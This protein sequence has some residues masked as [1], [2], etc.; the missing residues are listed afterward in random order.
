MKKRKKLIKTGFLLLTILG[1]LNIALAV[2]A[3]EVGVPLPAP[4]YVYDGLGQDEDRTR[5]TTRLSANWAE[6]PDPRV[7]GYQYAIGTSP[8]GT[9][10]VNWT[11]LPATKRSVTRSGLSLSH[12]VTYY[13][14]VRA[15]DE[16]MYPG[17]E[18]SSDGIR[19]DI[20]A[21]TLRV[22][23]SP[24]ALTF[25]AD[26]TSKD[27][28]Y[29]LSI[30][31]A[32]GVR[33]N[34]ER[35][36]YEQDG[37]I[38]RT[39]TPVIFEHIPP[40]GRLVLGR[41]I[42]LDNA[43]RNQILA[44]R[45]TATFTLR[46]V[47]SG[48]DDRANP[49][50]GSSTLE[51][52]VRRRPAERFEITGVEILL[53]TG[54]WGLDEE[55]RARIRFQASNGPGYVEGNLYIDDV[56]WRS[57]G[58]SDIE[59]EDEIETPPV[60][61]GT[62]GTHTLRVALVA[63][64]PVEASATYE[65]SV[66][67]SIMDRLSSLNILK[68]EGT[69]W[70]ILQEI[71]GTAT[72]VDVPEGEPEGGA[73]Y[74][75]N[76][77][78]KL[79][80][81]S[82]NNQVVDVRMENLVIEFNSADPPN[83]RIISG[84]LITPP[85]T[86]PGVLFSLYH[87]FLEITKVE[88]QG[89]WN[90][91][92][93]DADLNLPVVNQKLY[94][95]TG[96]TVRYDGIEG[97]SFDE[98]H[99]FNLCGLNF[100]LRQVTI[101]GHTHPP[102]EL[103]Y[104]SEEVYA[105]LSGEISLRRNGRD[106]AI[107]SFSGFRFGVNI[108]SGDVNVE[109]NFSLTD[110]FRFIPGNDYFNLQRLTFE[111]ER[112]GSYTYALRAEGEVR[113]PQPFDRFGEQNFNF[114]FTEE[115]IEGDIVLI[116][117]PTSEEKTQPE[118]MSGP[119]SDP[120][121]VPFWVCQLDLT[122]LGID[123]AF[124]DGNLR[125]E[126][127]RIKVGADLWVNERD[128][129][130]LRQELG[131]KDVP[132]FT[133][134]FDGNL[135]WSLPTEISVLRDKKI[136]LGSVW[137]GIE[138]LSIIPVPFALI[139]S[140]GFGIDVDVVESSVGIDGLRVDIDG[141]VDWGTIREGEFEVLDVVTIGV[142]SI[143]YSDS[144]STSTVK[145]DATD[146]G[147]RRSEE[148]LLSVSKYLRVVNANIDLAN[149]FSGN[150]DELLV[151]EET[152]GETKFALRG[153]DIDIAGFNLM[154]DFE[155]RNPVIS[156]AGAI[157]G[158]GIDLTVVGAVG[159]EERN[160]TFGLFV[161][162]D[163]PPTVII[164]P[165]LLVLTEVG[166]GFFYNPKQD[167]IK[168][169][170]ELCGVD[171]S[172]LA[173]KAGSGNIPS[174]FPEPDPGSFAMLLYGGLYCIEEATVKGQALISLTGGYFSLDAHAE[175]LPDQGPLA[176]G[177]LHF[178]VS[179]SPAFAEGGVWV[180][181]DIINLIEGDGYFEF[182]IFSH[183]GEAVWAIMGGAEL[184]VIRIIDI[185]SEFFMGPPGFM[186][187]GGI[188]AGIDLWIVSGGFSLE[189]MIWYER[190]PPD[191]T[192]GA[193][194]EGEVWGEVLGGLAGARAGLYGALI[195]P[196]PEVITGAYIS[197]EVCWVEV[198]SG[199][200]WISIGTR[201]I[202]GGTGR[203]SR[204]DEILD[205]A[206]NMADYMDR[207]MQEVKDSIVDMLDN[208]G[209]LDPKT[210]ELLG[211]MLVGLESYED[212]A[213]FYAW[214]GLGIPGG[215][216]ERPSVCNDILTNILWDERLYHMGEPK[217]L[218][219]I[220]AERDALFNSYKDKV[221]SINSLQEQIMLKLEER[222]P[223]IE[224]LT[225]TG[226]QEL[227]ISN[228]V[229]GMQYAAI[230]YVTPEGERRSQ[231][232]RVGFDLDEEMADTQKDQMRQNKEDQQ[233][234]IRS[235]I[236]RTEEFRELLGKVD[237][238]LYGRRMTEIALIG[239]PVKLASLKLVP[240]PVLL[241]PE[242]ALMDL[243]N[244]Y[245]EAFDSLMNYYIK[246]FGYLD[247]AY[248]VSLEK[249]RELR[250][251][252]IE[253]TQAL[254]TQ[255]ETL[256]LGWVKQLTRI[257]RSI[258]MDL[259]NKARE[260]V[261]AEGEE[262]PEDFPAPPLEINEEWTEDEWRNT[263][264]NFGKELWYYIPLSGYQKA[265]SSISLLPV[266]R[267]LY[268][269]KMNFVNA[270][271]EVTTHLDFVYDRRVRLYELLYDLYDELS[272][273]YAGYP[274]PVRE[275]RIDTDSLGLIEFKEI[276]LDRPAER[277]NSGA[278][279]GPDTGFVPETAP[280]IILQVERFARP[281][282][283]LSPEVILPTF[284]T[285]YGT[286]KERIST[287]LLPP[288]ITGFSGECRGVDSRAGSYA[289]IDS[290]F[291]AI[292]PVGVVEYGMKIEQPDYLSEYERESGTMTQDWFS[293]GNQVE[294]FKLLFVPGGTSHGEGRWLY[295][296]ARGPAGNYIY[297][298]GRIQVGYMTT[299]R[300][301]IDIADTTP[302]TTPVVDDEG[303][304]TRNT[305]RLYTR[306]ESSDPESGIAEY[307]YRVITYRQIGKIRTLIPEV[308]QDWTS[309]GV[310]EELN[311]RGLTLENNRTYF[312]QVKTKNG[313]G[314]W[315]PV[316]CSDGIR[317]D[318]VPPRITSL[319]FR[320]SEPEGE[321]S[322]TGTGLIPEMGMP[323]VGPLRFYPN[324]LYA[325]FA[326]EDNES[327]IAE[328]SF[329]LLDEN[330]S[331]LRTGTTTLTYLSLQ[332]LPLS[333]GATYTLSVTVRD[334][335]GWMSEPVTSEVTALFDDTTAPPAPSPRYVPARKLGTSLVYLNPGLYL[336]STSIVKIRWDPVYDPESGVYEYQVGIGRTREN[337]DVLPWTGVGR[338]TEYEN[339]SLKLENGQNYYLMVKVI[340]GAGLESV[341]IVGPLLVDTTPPV[342]PQLTFLAPMR[343][344]LCCQDKESLISL[345]RYAIYNERGER[346]YQSP[347]RGVSLPGSEITHEFNIYS[348]ELRH[349]HI[350]EPQ[351]GWQI[352]VVA[353]NRSGWQSVEAKLVI[354]ETPQLEMSPPAQLLR[355]RR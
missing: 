192:W 140:A 152:S 137:I 84:R 287:L 275:D 144:S 331:E 30:V 204:L 68:H 302:P 196:P 97:K 132:C 134:D 286:R 128:D 67:V 272:T 116:D 309:A 299:S 236:E 5:S 350:P 66:A 297:R 31:G 281:G 290:R 332:N 225:T 51:V 69:P 75:L 340:N 54:P 9:D 237:E 242:P 215:V 154:S 177:A 129:A 148:R 145:V 174:D 111:F 258:L 306:W 105:L 234:Y 139:I 319:Q 45:P 271:A 100:H 142:E 159:E 36:T 254:E 48:E 216:R 85:V 229:R 1:L 244:E 218:W 335:V 329:R 123:L 342:A 250:E 202:D 194:A 348:E 246:Y 345:Y 91:L 305:D 323:V 70:A 291:A 122:Y 23:S 333:H 232:L 165:A 14:T 280:R 180:D 233:E 325:R 86:P 316:G 81:A 320:Q 94:A 17:L 296:R 349:Q 92:K 55:V 127:S 15:V 186:L 34:Q 77:S 175:V 293:L 35:V 155:Y 120:T 157:E 282:T 125:D 63:P 52:E 191:T 13:F 166:G 195:M 133:I 346:K 107:T 208:L 64:N 343:V 22:T 339:N 283:T 40:G 102:I 110:P 245:T 187:S 169:I 136:D 231:T 119:D 114:R 276:I 21:V 43:L 49:V 25:L 205:E 285:Y 109:G 33:I 106:E 149:L 183:E 317:T 146:G 273:T 211:I 223:E 252:E 201:G 171:H 200:I 135:N 73:Y 121:Q 189:M 311:I 352:G 313:A 259:Y 326:G 10:V 150:F 87:D 101:S 113:L 269:R 115:R 230:E 42:T 217:G 104:S 153:V 220:R 321:R 161:T 354:P 284:G 210:R 347:W 7:A 60:P 58:V 330:G 80:V 2:K 184:E 257:R 314:D 170:R 278:G 198:W 277:V 76:G 124:I 300:S 138:D 8:G 222:L 56:G 239:K 103:G 315:S 298:Q 162:A 328:Y 255:A 168:E 20:G 197:V 83:S 74:S 53:P 18:I 337:P 240:Q 307:Q 268:E 238:L 118:P 59:D 4:A 82:L 167:Y 65:V 24:A 88:Y 353:R 341:G 228:P 260:R 160:L 62:A 79:R 61:T 158:A 47:F 178:L 221:T 203:N 241:Q 176:T 172:R 261:T 37:R 143:E 99:S 243:V 206:R 256:P 190:I 324:S 164:P 355:S 344:R 112:G 32:G 50:T 334:K 41:S 179:W 38:L 303:E 28:T 310:M 182:Y 89:G 219:Q 117:E 71:E 295:L 78:G 93:I 151:Y 251:R 288:E 227:S 308:V 173:A 214:E 96:I 336:Y 224:R 6:V 39:E 207:E 248:S 274:L 253:L 292:H 327:G 130:W 265:A 289:R 11:Y 226:E 351:P 266:S 322:S 213:I 279:A 263:C 72:Q 235:V 270:W 57:F 199:D 3:I 29:T 46:R 126:H 185:D 147:G 163:I 249:Y 312:I 338:A 304:W 294:N 181:V 188:R 98:E 212:I 262:L 318:L 264:T 108:D 131:T 267:D 12:G 26:E 95:L 141:N 90:H 193:Y 156:V 16:Q 27:V 19:V 44:G 209:T 247:R 301:S